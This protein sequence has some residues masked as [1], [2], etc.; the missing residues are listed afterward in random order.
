MRR[1]GGPILV[2]IGAFLV[3]VGLLA[4]FYAY[5]ALAVAPI[6]QNSVTNLEAPDATILDTATL[7]EVTTDLAAANKTAGDVAASEDAGD[8]IRVWTS[9]TSFRDGIGNIRSRSAERYAFDANTGEAVNCCDAFIETTDGDRQPVKREG[10]ISKY[11]FDTQKQDYKFWDG[12]LG[13]AV[14]TEFVEESEIDGLT[15]YQ[16]RYEVPTTV[17]GSREVPGSLLG[18]DESAVQADVQYSTITQHWVEPVT[19]AIIDRVSETANT[20]GYEGETVLTTTGGTFSYTDAQVAANVEDFSGK[21]SALSAVK[22]TVPL[23]GLILGLILIGAGVFLARRNE[24]AG[25]N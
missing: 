15:V 1:L 16:F 4:R 22:S 10:L 14:T 6:D 12:T 18:V 25:A 17:V 5:P 23:V 24:T 9:T 20:L 13:Q 7:S 19:G 11:P 8:D 3:V 21:A 2:G